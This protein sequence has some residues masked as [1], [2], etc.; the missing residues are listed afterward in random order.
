VRP[1]R[2]AAAAKAMLSFAAPPIRYDRR[3]VE[4]QKRLLAE[5]FTGIGWQVPRLL[6]DMWGAPDFYFDAICQVHLDR[7]YRDR[8]VLL[9]DAAYCGSPLTG[10]GTSLALVGAYVL[11]GELY[12]A[13]GDHRVAFPR[14]QEELREYVRQ[15]QRLPPGGVGGYLPRGR[16]AL[17]LRNQSMRASTTR[18]MRALIARQARRADAITLKAY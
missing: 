15:C 17:W 12:A 7:W 9:G 14:Y 18:P 8:T 6:D 11:A 3:D 16:L 2:D 10:L 5:R 4:Q 13:G 1:D